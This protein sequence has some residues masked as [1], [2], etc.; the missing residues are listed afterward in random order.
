[1]MNRPSYDAY[2]MRIAIAVATRSTCLRR[3]V[4]CVLVDGMHRILATGY[5]GVARGQPHCAESRTLNPGPGKPLE[6][7]YPHACEGASA[8]SGTDIDKCEAIHAE[9]NALVQCRDVD[10]IATAYVTTC[11]CPSCFK[12]LLATGCLTIVYIDAYP[13]SKAWEDVWL[14]M[15]GRKIRTMPR[16]SE[17]ER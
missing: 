1:M 7:I 5:N 12:L 15:P 8:M 16:V 3:S 13:T 14:T 2:F 17:V 4:G 6:T 10:A 11:P 9:Q